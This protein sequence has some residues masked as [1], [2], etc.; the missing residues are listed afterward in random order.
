MPQT[1]L[2]EYNFKR[3]SVINWILSVPLIFIF[4][5]PFLYLCDLLGIG[6]VASGIGAFLFSLPLLFTILHGHV[7]MALGSS[8]RHHYYIWLTGKPFTYGLLFHNAFTKTRFRLTLL[9]I[10]SLVLMAG[11]VLGS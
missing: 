6:A 2:S 7:T 3:I 11:L 9:A 5:W 4:G 8:H 1:E 10:S